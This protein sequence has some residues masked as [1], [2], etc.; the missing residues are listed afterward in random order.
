MYENFIR[1]ARFVSDGHLV[2]T[3]ESI[4]YSTVVSSDSVRTLTLVTAFKNIETT[5]VDV[6]NAFLLDDNIEKHWIRADPKF[7]SEQGKLFIVIIALYGL[8]IC[9][10]NF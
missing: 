8:K 6:N 5:S 7:G 4:T 1:K 3:P 10:C 9:K 2:N